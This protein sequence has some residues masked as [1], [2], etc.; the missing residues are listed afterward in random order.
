MGMFD[1]YTFYFTK[2]QKI[3]RDDVTC[4]FTPRKT[5]LYGSMKFYERHF[6]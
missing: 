4:T 5:V 6:K 2:F 1:N 3:N